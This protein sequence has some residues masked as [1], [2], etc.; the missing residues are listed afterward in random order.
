M[1]DVTLLLKVSIPLLGVTKADK[2]T[3]KNLEKNNVNFLEDQDQVRIE[4]QKFD[5]I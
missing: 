2:Q 3:S 4:N 1:H 5:D